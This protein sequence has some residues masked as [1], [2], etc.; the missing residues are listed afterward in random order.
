MVYFDKQVAILELS[1]DGQ[2]QGSDGMTVR[3]SWL[4]HWSIRELGRQKQYLAVEDLLLE[5][6]SGRLRALCTPK[7]ALPLEALER[8][9]GSSAIIAGPMKHW[10]R[11]QP[12]CTDQRFTTAKQFLG[13]T[14]WDESHQILGYIGDLQFAWPSGEL[15]AIEVSQGLLQ[16]LVRGR[17]HLTRRSRAARPLEGQSARQIKGV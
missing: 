9:H 6:A 7:G 5:R 13:R 8:C 12:S 15:A 2:E 10:L 1:S 3:A 11:P 4:L 16:D 17:Y 14:L